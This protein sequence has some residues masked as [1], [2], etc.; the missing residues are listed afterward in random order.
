M[1]IGKYVQLYSEDLELKNY[2]K[3][4]IDNYCSQVKCFLENFNSI[5]TKPSEVSEKQIKVWLL[6]A[7]TV[8]SR[9]HRISALKLFYKF[10][11]KQPLKFKNIEYPRGE[12]KLPIVLSVEEVQRMFDCCDN[13]KHKV[14]LSLLYSCGLRVSEL[15]N[16]QWSNIDRS[17]MV[18]NILG[19]KGNK[20]RQVM[21]AESLVPLLEKYFREYRSKTYVLNGQTSL[22]YTARSVGSVVKQLA[23]KAGI[24]KRVYTHLMR[25]NSFTHLFEAGVDITRIQKLAGHTNPRTTLLYTHISHNLI[26]SVPSPLNNIN[27]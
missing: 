7:K 10:T 25:H 17:R 4:T 5:A 19:G 8:N 23:Q 14:I 27:L 16:L 9:K 11:I 12:K 22:Q 3:N 26:S 20:D 13:L 6:E 1:N 24:N 18:I 2:S 21:L 15:I